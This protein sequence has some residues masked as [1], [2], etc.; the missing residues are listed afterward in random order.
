MLPAVC[1]DE[2]VLDVFGLGGRELQGWMLVR[3]GDKLGEERVG[4]R[5]RALIFV[6]PLT[7]FSKELDIV[8]VR[9]RSSL[10]VSQS[11]WSRKLS[12]YADSDW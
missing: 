12:I 7:D 8:V 9:R 3:E 4:E 11:R 1:R 5:R 6:A 10:Y 2:D